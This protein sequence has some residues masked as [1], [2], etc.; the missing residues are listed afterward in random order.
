MGGCR[1]N[2]LKKTRFGAI[3][4]T[5]QDDAFFLLGLLMAFYPPSFSRFQ[6]AE[7]AH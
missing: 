2:E 7:F 1:A 4:P 3:L 6:V 5:S